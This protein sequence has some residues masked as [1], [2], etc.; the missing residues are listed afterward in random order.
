LS[1]SLSSYLLC[2]I[3]TP[4]SDTTI[5]FSQTKLYSPHELSKRE[6]E[7]V[8]EYEDVNPEIA[9]AV[10]GDLD[11]HQKPSNL[12]LV[13]EVSAIRIFSNKY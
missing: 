8:L 11:C 9:N 10:S 6:D 5:P 12:R 2:G 4:R 3:H 13:S 7:C 1:S